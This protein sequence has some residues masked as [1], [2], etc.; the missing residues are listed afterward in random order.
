MGEMENETSYYYKS[1]KL[2]GIM[3][4]MH[5]SSM[6]SNRLSVIISGTVTTTSENVRVIYVVSATL[7]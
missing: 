6:R 1:S 4:S 2:P 3:I 7:R 5:K